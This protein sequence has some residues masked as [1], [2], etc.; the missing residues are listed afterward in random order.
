[1]IKDGLLSENNKKLEC[2]KEVLKF[3]AKEKFGELQRKLNKVEL[4]RH[5]FDLQAENGA[6]DEVG[7]SKRKEL[8]SEMWKLS[9]TTD[10]MWWQKSRVK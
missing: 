8:R 3:W 4:E 9:R 1:M 6:L 5:G 2:M 7:R 10:R